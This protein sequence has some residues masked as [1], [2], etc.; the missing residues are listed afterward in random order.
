PTLNGFLGEV[1]LVADIDDVEENG[2]QVLMMTLHS[3]KGL[4]FPVVFLAGMEDGM[5]PGY[6]SISSEDPADLEEERRLCYV[7]IT[8]AQR[9]LYLT[10]ARQRMVRGEIHFNRVS[11]F[12]EDIPQEL[13]QTDKKTAEI[14]TKDKKEQE[15]TQRARNVNRNAYRQAKDAFRSKAF[16][17]QQFQVKKADALTYSVGDRVKHVKFGEGTV[18]AIVEGGRDYEV[19][20]DFD[21]AGIKKMF[22]A[23]AKLSRIG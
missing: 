14:L 11:R 7:G 17:P 1:A 22:A 21:R 23:F 18:M 2:N 20:V 19:T 4:E 13:F 3:A 12:V 9:E 15:E 8:R 5:F 16:V 6:M 10:A